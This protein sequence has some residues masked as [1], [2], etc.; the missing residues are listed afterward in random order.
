[1]KKPMTKA[2]KRVADKIAALGCIVCV[3]E[4]LGETP[5]QIHHCETGAGGRRDHDKIIGLCDFH[6]NGAEGVHKLSRPIWQEK[7]GTEQQLMLQV[8][9]EIGVEFAVRIERVEMA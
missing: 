2:Q 9:H 4:G 8:R 7:Y 5:C 1:M 6:H 3:N